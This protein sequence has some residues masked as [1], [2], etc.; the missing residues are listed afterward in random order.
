MVIN[1][2]PF[3]LRFAEIFRKR[4]PFA[5]SLRA[6]LIVDSYFMIREIYFMVFVKKNMV[7]RAKR[8]SNCYIL[9][10]NNVRVCVCSTNI[11]F[12][13]ERIMYQVRVYHTL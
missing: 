2:P 8:V 9:T 4:E 12:S 1:G 6:V 5:A 10:E 3:F 11:G 13:G 7:I